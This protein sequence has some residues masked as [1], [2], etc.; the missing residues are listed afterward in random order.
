[1]LAKTNVF[2]PKGGRSLFASSGALQKSIALL[3]SLAIGLRNADRLRSRL[4]L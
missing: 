2:A 1:M 3:K 4:F